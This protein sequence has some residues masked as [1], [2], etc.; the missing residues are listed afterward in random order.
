[1][2]EADEIGA[3]IEGGVEG[4]RRADAA[5]LDLEAPVV[6]SHGVNLRVPVVNLHTVEVRAAIS[7]ALAMRR[8]GTGAPVRS[9]RG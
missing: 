1:M 7:T 3:R 6:A 8:E 2:D 4:L 9:R 5:D